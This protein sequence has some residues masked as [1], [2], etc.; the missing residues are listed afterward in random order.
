MNQKR[1]LAFLHYQRYLGLTDLDFSN[2]LH[3]LHGTWISYA[4]QAIVVVIFVSALVAA[5]AESLFYLDTQTKTGMI[6]DNAVI[7]ATSISQLLANLWFRAQQQSQVALLHRLS[8][9]VSRLQVEPEALPHPRWFYRIWLVVC[10]LYVI[11]MAHFATK[12][13]L[14]NMEL[15]HVLTLL[16]FALRCILA[17]FQITCYS[18]VVWILRTSLRVQADQLKRMVLT[19]A[20]ISSEDVALSLKVHDEIL[21]LGQRDVV[22]V[23]GGVLVFLFMY[24]VMQCVLIFYL[25]SLSIFRTFKELLF[26]LAW[27]WPM[28]FYLIL[29]LAANDVLNQA[30]KGQKVK[31][32]K[33]PF[34]CQK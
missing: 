25:S 33:D 1:L 17:N 22:E 31:G 14:T 6:F 4:T 34:G 8:H 20:T 23:Y 24:Q 16:G 2:G 30:L 13:W 9:V 10:F 18:G 3:G 29:P 7:I 11:M 15:S 21:L 32:I 27:L 5:L 12:T 26:I 28:L 19:A